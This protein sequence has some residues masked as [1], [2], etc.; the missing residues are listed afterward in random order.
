ML[1][2]RLRRK[3]VARAPQFIGANAF[4]GSS[5]VTAYQ[6]ALTQA[7]D[8]LVAVLFAKDGSPRDMSFNTP[9]GW[10]LEFDRPIGSGAGSS[11]IACYSKAATLSGY[12]S[13][14]TFSTSS[15]NSGFVV[16][17]LTVRGVTVGVNT[18]APTL[19]AVDSNSIALASISPPKA[20]LLCGAA[21]G[22]GS[23]A[24][25]KPPSMTQAGQAANSIQ[26]SSI[27]AFETVNAAGPTG[28]RT[29]T[30][31]SADDLSGLLF[32]IE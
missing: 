15:A 23:S 7:G 3:K 32:T 6:N 30:F 18:I 4:D 26:L 16:I 17:L 21:S 22:F 27:V 2:K 28:T 31:G 11:I 29:F 24:W 10:E 9:A 13:V 1:A 12:N 25:T 20:A 19:N 8:T 14:G 5:S